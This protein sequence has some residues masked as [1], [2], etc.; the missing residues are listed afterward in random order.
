MKQSHEGG[1]KTWVTIIRTQLALK[2]VQS[3]SKAGEGVG[4]KGN[5]FS[6]ALTCVTYKGLIAENKGRKFLE[7]V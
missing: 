4:K 6:P 7:F 2:R 5:Q 1:E 3:P